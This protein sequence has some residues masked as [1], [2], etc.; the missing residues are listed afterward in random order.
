MTGISDIIDLRSS[1]RW[2]ARGA[3]ALAI[4]AALTASAAGQNVVAFANGEPITAL[5]I[6]QRSKL[7]EL[8]THKPPPRQEVLDELIND[9]LKIREG[10]R[11]SV[12]PSNAD[13]DSAFMSMA[14]RMRLNGDQFTQALAKSGISANTLKSRIR[15]DIVWQSLVRG[16]YAVD[17]EIGEKDVLAEMIA[18]KSGDDDGAQSYEYTLR[19]ILFVVPSGSPESLYEDRKRDAEALRG[20]FRSCDEGLPI[21][22]A[23]R[24]VAVRDPIVRNSSDVPAG[25]L[26]KVSTASRSDS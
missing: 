12:D 2:A 10:K 14:G 7:D 18:K 9:K 6:E 23:L 13:V 20:R 11:Y 26:R 15:A 16:R 17:L 1:A 19:P 22:R 5:D 3:A 24:D 25:R 21:A 8:S 4:S